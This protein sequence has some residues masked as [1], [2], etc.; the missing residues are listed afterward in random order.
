MQLPLLLV[1]VFQRRQELGAASLAITHHCDWNYASPLQLHQTHLGR[2]SLG[3][4]DSTAPAALCPARRCA[5]HGKLR[6]HQRPTQRLTTFEAKK[7]SCWV[8]SRTCN[9][10]GA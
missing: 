1:Q 4:A 3:T 6:R 9:A 7:A 5:L 2:H 8:V 10:E